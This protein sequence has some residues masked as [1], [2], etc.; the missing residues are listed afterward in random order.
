MSLSDRFAQ[1]L[2][3]S[4]DVSSSRKR[5]ILKVTAASVSKTVTY[6]KKNLTSSG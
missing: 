3:A 5:D 6:A 4:E 1:N 2:L